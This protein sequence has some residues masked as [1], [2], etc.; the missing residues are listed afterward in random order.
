MADSCLGSMARY[1]A[2]LVPPII[3]ATA[4]STSPAGIG[5]QA[6]T[7]TWPTATMP[8]IPLLTPVLPGRA[9]LTA[10]QVL[11]TNSRAFRKS[12]EHRC[13]RGAK[14]SGPPLQSRYTED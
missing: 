2:R 5:A 12:F 11:G 13:H 7:M 14:A 4:H 1:S 8:R 3:A 9:L 6:V 10:T